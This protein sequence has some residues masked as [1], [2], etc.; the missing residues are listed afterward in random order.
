MIEEH[1]KEWIIETLNCEIPAYGDAH[2]VEEILI[3][4]EYKSGVF[5]GVC[6]TM[7]DNMYRAFEAQT[8]SY[9]GEYG[10]EIDF[11]GWL[12]GLSDCTEDEVYE[13]YKEHGY[14]EK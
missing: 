2:R 4:S 13:W 14:Y 11:Y 1:D 7:P 5:K 10:K 6:R 9:Y 8:E 12:E 3:D